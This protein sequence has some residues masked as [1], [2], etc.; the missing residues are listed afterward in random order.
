LITTGSTSRGHVSSFRESEEFRFG[1]EGEHLIGSALL[2]VGAAVSPLYQFKDHDA[3]PHLLVADGEVARRVVLPDL[4]CWKDGR[5]FFAEVKRKRRWVRW[6][7]RRVYNGV[8]RGL[9]T[10]FDLHLWHEYQHVRQATGA[11]LWVFFLHEPDPKQPEH[12]TGVFV[13]ELE[14]LEPHVREWDGTNETNGSRVGQ[15]EALFPAWCLR[16]RWELSEVQEAV[17]A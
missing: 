17:D 5:H 10:G 2:R 9:E 14:K 3:A 4:T 7:E 8:K 6:L 16:K 12:P 15:P 11:P 13:Q 1:E